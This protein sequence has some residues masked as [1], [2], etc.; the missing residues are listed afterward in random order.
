VR[1]TQDLA[2]I[3]VSSFKRKRAFSESQSLV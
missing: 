1:V 2:Y 3:A